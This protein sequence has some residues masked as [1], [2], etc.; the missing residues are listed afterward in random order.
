M[1]MIDVFSL[2][3]TKY[4]KKDLEKKDLEITLYVSFF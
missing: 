1:V 4:I 3:E 2:L